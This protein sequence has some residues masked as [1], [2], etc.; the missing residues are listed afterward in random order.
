MYVTA[1]SIPRSM[2]MRSG[3]PIRE[4]SLGIP[5]HYSD[6]GKARDSGTLR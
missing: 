4:E 1:K 6:K 3:M 2:L 5:L